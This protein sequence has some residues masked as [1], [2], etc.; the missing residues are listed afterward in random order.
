[1]QAFLAAA[2][3]GT[4]RA[5]LD[6]LAKICATRKDFDLPAHFCA[7]LQQVLGLSKFLNCSCIEG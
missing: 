3:K 5:A 6:G 2:A 4:G 1:M 7:Q